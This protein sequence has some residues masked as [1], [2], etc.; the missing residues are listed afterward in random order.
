MSEYAIKKLVQAACADLEVMT[1]R[2]FEDCPGT[3]IERL[4]ETGL[5]VV[6]GAARF[7]G[8]RAPLVVAPAGMLLS[9]IP[10]ADGSERIPSVWL[11]RQYQVLDWKVDYVVGVHLKD[12]K[13][14]YLVIE[15]DGHDF[16]E[17]TKEQAAKDRSRDR[18]LQ[19]AGYRIHRYTGH[20]IY[21]DA[22]GC[23]LAAIMALFELSYSPDEID[24]GR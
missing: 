24:G 11:W 3:P 21:K 9:G 8:A 10:A 19:D 14:R 4:F 12:E 23:A 5:W 7:L 18:R 20:E 1:V 6:T 16:H 13:P 17:R 15:C 2:K 22:Y